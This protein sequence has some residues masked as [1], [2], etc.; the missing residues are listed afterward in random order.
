MLKKLNDFLAGLPMTI[1]AGVFLLLDLVPHLMEEFGGTPVQLSFLPFDPAWVTIAISGI[2]LLYLAIWRIIHNP[3]ISKISSALLIC[4]AMFAAIA[5]GDLFAAGEVVFIMAIGALLE[6]A[7]TNRAKKGLKKLISLAPTKGRRLKDGKEEM[8]PAEEIRQGDILRILP[9]ETIPVD[10]TIINGETSVDQSIMTGESLPVDKGVGEE[11]FCGTINRFGSIDISATKVGENSSLQKLIRMVQDAEN[12]QAPM[13]RIADR[14]A[15]WLV[16]VALL[17]AILAY[18]FTGNIVTA[19]TVLV[20]FCPCALVLATPTAIMA[21]IGQATKHGVIIKSGEALEKMGKVDTIAFDKTGTLTY[22]RLDVSDM[23]SFDES[24]S[25]TDLLSLAA[26]AEAK[27]EHPLGK[28]IVAYAKTKDVPLVESTAF[29]MTTGKGIFAEVDNRSLLCGNEK[30]LTENGVSIDNKVQSALERLRTQGK[31][32]ILVA[33]GQKCIG[34]IALSDVLRPEAKDMVSRLSDMHT[35]TV[36]LTGDHQKTADYFAQQIGI[37]E[38]RAELLPEEK[39]QSIEKLQAENHKVC[40]IGDGVND[41][42]ALKTADVSVAMGSMGSD[43]AVDAAEVALM[44][45]DISKI[46]YLKRLSNATVKTIKASI[47]LSMCINFVA[48]V[49]SLMEVLTPT[50]GALVHNA[51][52]CFVVLIAALLYD[53]KFE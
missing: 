23:L 22:G 27:S 18:V 9:G 35:R 44:S 33:E 43:I 10:G 50:T 42:P 3:G 8:I 13:Q 41:A 7:T 37:S 39:V 40:M 30:F 29:R 25:E 36:L 52:S 48:I 4:I 15:S 34:V 51:G 19:V 6:E 53:R 1:V 32:S 5:I 21:A 26:S 11:V 2:P 16:P 31:A 46:P 45:D 47:T 49:L 17:I 38:V 14:V 28:A 24:I 12:K 20:V